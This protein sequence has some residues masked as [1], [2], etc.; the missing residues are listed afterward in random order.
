MLVLNLV[1]L[2]IGIIP[3]KTK[4]FHYTADGIIIKGNRAKAININKKL[5]ISKKNADMRGYYKSYFHFTNFYFKR[6]IFY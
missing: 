6:S 1:V 4:A 2:T 3:I 5:Y